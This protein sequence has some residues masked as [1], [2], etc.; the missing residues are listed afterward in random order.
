MEGGADAQ[1]Q[2]LFFSIGSF[3]SCAPPVPPFRTPRGR[4]H[5][6]PF[7]DFLR[8][9]SSGKLGSGGGGGGADMAPVTVTLWGRREV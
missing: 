1:L 4:A 3:P 5:P 8:R 9:K 2:C 7:L 6:M